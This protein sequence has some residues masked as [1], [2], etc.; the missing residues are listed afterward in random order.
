M[1]RSGA[2]RGKDYNCWMMATGLPWWSAR[3]LGMHLD[4]LACIL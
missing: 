1:G 2:N 3:P 4:N